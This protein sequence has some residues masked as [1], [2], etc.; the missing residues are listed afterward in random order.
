MS[1]ATVADPARLLQGARLAREPLS[2]DALGTLDSLDQAYAVQ[3]AG[4]ALRRDSGER[5]CGVKMGFTSRAKMLQMGVSEMIIGQLTDAM[6]VP[7]GEGLDAGAFIHPRIEPEIALLLAR[8]LPPSPGPDDLARSV[9]AVAP[10]LEIIDSRFRDFRFDLNAVVADNT[11]AAAFVVG[12][13]QRLPAAIDNLGLAMHVSSGSAA[14]ARTSTH[15]GTTA[16]ILGDP[17]RSLAAAARLAAR[18][19]LVI[20]AGAV[21]LC[22]AATAA[23][24]LP[25]TGLVELEMAGLGRVR[26]RVAPRSAAA[27]AT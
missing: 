7:D 26:L 12:S 23:Q 1:A 5:L 14:A 6:C 8:D 15:V 17:W 2:H 13:W 3:R 11:S 21:V 19:G 25:Q 24:P 4:I 10:A 22:G 20:P 27:W 16:A 9:A 18:H